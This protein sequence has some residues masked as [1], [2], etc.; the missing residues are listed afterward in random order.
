MAIAKKKTAAKR[1]TAAAKRTVKYAAKAQ[2]AAAHTA[3]QTAKSASHAASKGVAQWQKGA[4]EWAKQSA[5]L[6]Q[7]PFAQGGDMGKQT[8]D[9]MKMGSD[10]MNQFF[11][12]AKEA[13]A[14][15]TSGAQ[16]FNPAQ[17]FPQ[18]AQMPKFD[19]AAA[20]EK[21][22]TFA[23]ESAEQINKSAGNANRAM[24]ETMELSRENGETIVEVSN[25]AISVSK[26]LGAELISYMN[27]QFAQNVELS[28]QVLSCRTL[29][30]MFD[31]A[32]RVMKTN[33]DSFFNESVK[34]SELLFQCAN[35]VS[36]PLND[37]I[38]ETSQRLTK[39]LS[40]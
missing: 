22:S 25:T 8:E 10:M 5:K 40:A 16:S 36:D 13:A 20:Q 37:R 32:T 2:S 12:Q 7:L 14:K 28:K 1:T 17:L 23:R 11:G 19:A 15:A 9:M 33:L 38:S 4:S 39:I 6:Y 30:D 31:L 34:I 35:D 18:S 26:E 27:K 24:N 3:S 21:L 29:N